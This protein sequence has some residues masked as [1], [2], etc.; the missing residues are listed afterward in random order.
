M[1]PPQKRPV[2]PSEVEG[3]THLRSAGTELVPP[4]KRPVI[5]SEVEGSTHPRPAGTELVPPAEPIDISAPES[6]RISRLRCA[7]LEMTYFLLRAI[8]RP[9]SRP[10]VRGSLDCARD[11]RVGKCRANNGVGCFLRRKDLSS[12]AKSRDPCTYG[13]Q[14]PNWFLRR[15]DLSSPAKSRDLR[16]HGQQV[17]NWFH[18]RNQRTL[19]RP[20]VP[21]SLDSAAL[22]SR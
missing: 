7:S 13:Q 16:T 6:A 21:G 9:L 20:K 5:P 22:R 15:K 19:Q 2:I 11:D 3:S 17:P 1:V 14:V 12:P 18:R 10:G 8:Q 4:Q